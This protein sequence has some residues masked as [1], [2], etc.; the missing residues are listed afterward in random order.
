MKGMGRKGSK[1]LRGIQ[2]GESGGMIGDRLIKGKSI[3]VP[4]DHCVYLL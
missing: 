4:I 1:G 2:E 3:D